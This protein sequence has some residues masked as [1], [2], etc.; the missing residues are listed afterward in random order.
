MLVV[1]LLMP[2]GIGSMQDRRVVNDGATAG[3]RV[4]PAVVAGGFVFVSGL[5]AAGEGGKLEGVG[6]PGADAAVLQQ[7]RPVLEQ[8][9]S[10]LAQVMSVSVF[11]ERAADFAGD[12]RRLSRVLRRQASR[13][14]RPW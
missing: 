2:E 11:L 3:R 5:V 1:A 6:H 7:L 9:G 14:G 10:S 8:A 13:R 12:E 4:S